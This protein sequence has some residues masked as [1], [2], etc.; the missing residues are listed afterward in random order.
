[1]DVWRITVA[2]LR[3]WYVLVP[4]LG[5]TAL[6]VMAVGRGVEP[7]YDVTGATM[8]VPGPALPQSPNPYGAPSDANN[9][10]A[11]VLNSPETRAVIADKGLIAG[12]QVSPQSRST[13]MN[14]EV[15]GASP[16]QAVETGIAVFQ[17]AATEL[18]DRQTA[19]GIRPTEQYSLD[20]LQQPSVSGAVTDGKLRNMAVVGVL[21][22]AISLAIAVLFDDVLG[23]LRRRRTRRREQAVPETPAVSLEAQAPAGQSSPA[24]ASRAPVPDAGVPAGGAAA[25][26]GRPTSQAARGTQRGPRDAS[27]GPRQP[28]MPRKAKKAA[29]SGR[30][31]AASGAGRT[32]ASDMS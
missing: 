23:L 18:V 28:K 31:G 20:V 26:S 12:Y 1:M 32:A 25:P 29:G 13:I 22:G 27:T 7:E 4:L 10:M 8:V 19:A 11:I 17:Q 2:A 15:R 14:L 3:R 5:L 6:M 16:E 9:A 24:P 21:G 30:V